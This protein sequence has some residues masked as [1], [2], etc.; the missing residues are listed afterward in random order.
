M[1]RPRSGWC[2]PACKTTAWKA[3]P[4]PL[5]QKIEAGELSFAEQAKSLLRRLHKLKGQAGML[6]YP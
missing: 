4:R 2:R 5:A 6:G 3:W 1:S